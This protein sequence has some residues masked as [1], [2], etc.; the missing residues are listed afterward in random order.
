VSQLVAGHACTVCT[1]NTTQW[2]L[3]TINGSVREALDNEMFVESEGKAQGDSTYC[4]ANKFR[5]ACTDGTD[6]MTQRKGT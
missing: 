4:F 5:H 3:H 6:T 2:P 1:D